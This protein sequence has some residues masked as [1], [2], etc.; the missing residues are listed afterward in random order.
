MNFKESDICPMCGETT[1]LEHED[2]KYHRSNIE[3][4]LTSPFYHCYICDFEYCT[5]E[6][7]QYRY[8]KIIESVRN[9]K[10]NQVFL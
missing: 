4:V 5:S 3:I 9:E 6:M 7:E 10:I 1:H 8:D 2:V